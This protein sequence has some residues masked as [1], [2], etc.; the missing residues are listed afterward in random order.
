MYEQ[1]M[2]RAKE[3]EKRNH[4]L[5]SEN[6]RLTAVLN[7]SLLYRRGIVMSL[8]FLTGRDGWIQGQPNSD[9]Y[10]EGWNSEAVD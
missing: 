8:V 6:C 9:T 4:I 1:S 2:F 10:Q 5:S 3:K 7:C